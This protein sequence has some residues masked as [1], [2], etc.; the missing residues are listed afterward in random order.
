MSKIR[1]ILERNYKCR[2]IPPR[3]VFLEFNTNKAEAEIE[4]EF[5]RRKEKWKKELLEKLP[6]ER[7][8]K[9]LASEINGVRDGIWDAG[10]NSCLTKVKKLIEEV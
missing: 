8:E 7:T 9:H 2:I 5:Q 10:Y 4:A 1:E 6:K 3:D